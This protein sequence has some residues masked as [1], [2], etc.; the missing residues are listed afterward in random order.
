MSSESNDLRGIFA[1]DD[2]KK[3]LKDAILECTRDEVHRVL[4]DLFRRQNATNPSCHQQTNIQPAANI[5][6]RRHTT[7]SC[8]KPRHLST[9][10]QSSPLLQQQHSPARS[11][12]LRPVRVP[13]EVAVPIESANSK[14]HRSTSAILEKSVDI[15]TRATGHKP[16]K[17]SLH[18][19]KSHQ[20]DKDDSSS[21]DMI[22][23][24]AASKDYEIGLQQVESWPVLTR[25]KSLVSFRP[26]ETTRLMQTSPQSI[27]NKNARPAT[28]ALERRSSWVST[29]AAE[30]SKAVGLGKR[31]LGPISAESKLAN[32]S[33]VLPT[34]LQVY[35]WEN[36]LARNIIN[37][38]SN[39]V[40]SD[41][42]QCDESVDYIPPATATS[43]TRISSSRAFFENDEESSSDVEDFQRI[44]ISRG[45]QSFSCFD[46]SDNTVVGRS[47]TDVVPKAS[48]AI[49]SRRKG[50]MSANG[51]LRLRMIWLTGTSAISNWKIIDGEVRDKLISLDS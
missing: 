36:E 38:F 2:D 34:S 29:T 5:N 13:L 3:Q 9:L 42:K 12:S 49:Q 47:D 33:M 46:V 8:T 40:R 20:D 45:G 11:L 4:F 17:F 23:V 27:T 26:S 7:R 31:L 50:R 39:K 15:V 48:Q 35:E 6:S 28:T 51:A 30:R 43:S 41:I 14:I 21:A 18:D 25:P 22:N 1:T 44:S 19:D 10:L 24:E 16:T 37:V 32:Y